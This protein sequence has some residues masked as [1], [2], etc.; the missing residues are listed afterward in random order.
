MEPFELLGAGGALIVALGVGTIAHELSHALA[1][2]ALGVAFEIEWL[3]DRDARG[4]RSTR[5]PWATVTPRQVPQDLPPWRLRVAALM[6]LTL[7]LPLPLILVGVLPDPLAAGDPIL[8]SATV[9]WLACA[10]PS[11]QD[12]SLVWHAGQAIQRYAA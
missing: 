2:R 4:L 12:F 1:L 8:A 9:G 7:A 3:P 5:G 6:P 10:L 11:P